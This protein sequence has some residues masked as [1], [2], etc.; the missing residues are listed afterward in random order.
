[1]SIAEMLNNVVPNPN[2]AKKSKELANQNR[3]EDSFDS[4]SSSEQPVPKSKPVALSLAQKLKIA[5]LKKAE[6][7][8]KK[9][10][11]KRQDDPVREDV[12]N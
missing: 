5:R 2:L 4:H 11:A 1:M 8:E 9:Q 12:D 6:R 3:F 10:R 7:E